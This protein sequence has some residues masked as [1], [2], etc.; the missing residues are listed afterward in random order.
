M[1]ELRGQPDQLQQRDRSERGVSVGGGDACGE[2]DVL[3]GCEVRQQVPAL[4]HIGNSVRAQGAAGGG[5]DRRERASLPLDRARGRLDEAAEHVQERRLTGA[6]TAEQGEAVLLGDRQIDAVQRANGRLALAVAYD[7]T[8]AGD[9]YLVH[10]TRPSC[11]SITRST[12]SATRGEWVTTTTVLPNSA[13]KRASA[14]STI[15]SFR[16]SSSAVGSSASTSGASRA[17]AAAIAS[18]CCSPPDRA[19]ARVRSRRRRSNASS[20][21]STGTST[22]LRPASRRA[23]ATFSRADIPDH[24]LPLWNTIDA[25][26]A[27]KAANSFSSSPA[28]ERPNTRTSPADGWSSAAARWSIVLFPE[29]D[30]PKTATNSRGS[31]RSSR[32][33]S[34]T[35]S[36]GPER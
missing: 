14:S 36:T 19:P 6:G 25:S 24:R 29:P 17:A 3:E 13:R 26:R 10:A 16:S 21:R 5:V 22:R 9:H 1:V 20:A 11:S 2:G 12:A 33:R 4:E 35:V 28:S 30:G 15:R 18:R 7:D 8:V 32:P 31:T 27:R 34:A 23:S